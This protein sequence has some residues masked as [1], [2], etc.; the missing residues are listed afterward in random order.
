[1]KDYFE[2]LDVADNA[3][4]QAIKKAYKAMLEKYPAGQFPDRNRE[5]EEAFK[6]LSNPAVRSAC[7][8]FH[9]MDI[10]LK[11]AYSEAHDAI[12]ARKYG[13][14]A[15]VL[16][17][18]IKGEKHATHLNYLLGIA[19][20]NLDKPVKAMKVLE[21]V[22]N[23][24]PYDLDLTMLFIKACLG[25]KKY[26]KA[27]I[28]A[29]DCYFDDKNNF[30]LIHL[31]TECYML[32]EEYDQVSSLLIKALENPEFV[33]KRYNFGS[34]LTYSLFM[35]KKYKES[36]DMMD[37]LVD[38]PVELYE[39]NESLELFLHVLNYY[40]AGQMF[41]EADRCAGILLKLCPGREDI[42]GV[43][44]GIEKI[45]KL[46]P[47]LAGFEEDGFIP[48]LLKVYVTNGIYPGNQDLIPE[49]RQKAYI[50]LLEYQIL[51]DCSN[52]LMALRYMKNK[53]PALYE[54][55]AEFFDNV[56]DSRERK[57]LY[58]KNK[59]L[60][61]QYQ[62]VIEDMMNEWDEEYGDDDGD[63]DGD[64]WDFDDE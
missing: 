24:Y 51:N 15:K 19:Y 5:I 38:F 36:L 54:L 52:C 50:V 31:L 32:M 49:E 34:K 25:A 22:K 18:V 28:L 48:E 39:V 17:K 6:A 35:E 13:K 41:S 3:G 21:S 64:G 2:V 40:I 55:K 62:G 11:R 57:K 61:Y 44:D 10:A 42:A 37:R 1:M 12:E 30:S 9:R 29:K 46:E 16:E 47:E 60:F 14:A 43:K 4:E 27:L 53:Y 58:N 45:L 26:E 7:I 63:P 8:E 20:M 59:A 33:E 56:Q 23:D